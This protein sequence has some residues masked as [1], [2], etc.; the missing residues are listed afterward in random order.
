MARHAGMV[1]TGSGTAPL[2]QLVQQLWQGPVDSGHVRVVL[3][4][5]ADPSWRTVELYWVLPGIASARLLV[6]GGSRKLTAASL[7]HYRKLRPWTTRLVRNVLAAASAVGI[8]PGRGALHVQVRNNDDGVKAAAGL[9]LATISAHLRD[10]PGEPGNSTELYCSMGIR[11]GDNRKPTLQLIDAHGRPAGYAKLAWNE[12]SGGFIR[13]EGAALAEVGPLQSAMKVP[14]LLC[15]GTQNGF[16]FL[17][18][19]PL[20][21]GVRAV[22][23][24][25]AAPSPA[26][27]YSLCPIVRVD[28]VGS[29]LHFQSLV[30]R[31]SRLTEGSGGALAA[32]TSALAATIQARDVALPVAA[33]WHGDLVPWNTARDEAGQLWCWDWETAEA[34]A[35]AGLDAV[36]W[37]F[38][39]LRENRSGPV[40]GNLRAAVRDA[41]Q[42]L[43]AAGISAENFQDLAGIYALVVAERAWTLATNQGSWQGAWI[44]EEEL[45]AFVDSARTWLAESTVQGE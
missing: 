43:H 7:R 37:M 23:G 36:H 41:Q 26:E 38:S 27:L 28:R 11:T 30:G 22:R 31:L 40:A 42:H 34:D 6:P 13:T 18:T 19:A 14:D 12:S 24:A 29:T 39:V 21:A 3:D 17:V 25:V 1:V 15:A 44:T 45:V 10:A 16:P 20:P 2:D 32:S 8:T 9:P 33:R 35:V 4:P 5:A